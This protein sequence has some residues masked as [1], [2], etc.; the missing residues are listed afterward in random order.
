MGKPLATSGLMP[1]SK[2]DQLIAKANTKLDALKIERRGAKLGLRG[3]LPKKPEDGKGKKRQ[4]VP[5]GVYANPEG[6]KIALARA[7]QAE[8]DLALK[9]W[10]WSKWIE[11]GGQGVAEDS[12]SAIAQRFAE[13]KQKQVKPASFRANYLYPLES[14]PD[15]PLTQEMLELHILRRSSPGTW[16]RKND[17]MVFSALCKFAGVEVNLRDLGKGYSAKPVEPDDLPTDAEVEK[18]WATL[19][20]TGWEWVYGMMAAY[21]L[22]PHEVFAI[23]DPKG[24]S[25]SNG[26]IVIKDDSKT[27][28]RDVR[29]LPDKWRELFNLS[30]VI[31]P[32]IKIEGRDNQQL[33]QRVSANLRHKIP[34]KPYALRH[35]WAI[36][37]AVLG[38]ADSV[39]A[40][41]MGHSLDVH[42][43]TYHSG[44]SQLQ[45][46]AIWDQA[47]KAA[48][49]QEET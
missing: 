44:I 7:K 29:P 26:K 38:V 27:G 47:N 18:I 23:V 39:A 49:Q 3:T 41:W 12:A 25:S 30:K 10:D 15:K 20:G 46:D 35:A 43:K 2:I 6:V 33:G 8:S 14:L 31:L 13:Y 17:V 28:R 9:Q 37:T 19:E 42:N 21:G 45:H 24:V 16:T 22:R 5:L 40:R 1:D 4:R 32:N 11:D 34:H 36:R 48:A